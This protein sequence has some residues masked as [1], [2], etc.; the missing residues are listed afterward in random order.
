MHMSLTVR[1]PAPRADRPSY[2][3][4]PRDSQQMQTWNEGHFWERWSWQ[5]ITWSP[6]RGGEPSAFASV[7][8]MYSIT[9]QSCKQVRAEGD[10]RSSWRR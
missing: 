4:P 3:A 8:R 2:V 10:P 7:G 6:G 1:R 9:N 5:L